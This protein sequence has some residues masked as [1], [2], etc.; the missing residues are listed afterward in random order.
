MANLFFFIALLAAFGVQADTIPDPGIQKE[1]WCGDTALC[2][3]K[4]A[5]E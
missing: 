5:G 2:Y 3:D 1:F 4:N